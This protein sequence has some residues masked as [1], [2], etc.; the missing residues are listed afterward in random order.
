MTTSKNN[1]NI[2]TRNELSRPPIDLI[3]VR[4]FILFATKATQVRQQIS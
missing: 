2:L 3:I 1:D 4:E